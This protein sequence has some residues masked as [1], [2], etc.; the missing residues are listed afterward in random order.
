[1]KTA[2][3]RRHD[4]GMTLPE[5]LI[6]V[7]VL[8]MIMSVLAS[9]VIVTL[10]QQ[11]NTTG[12]LNV[13]RSEQTIGMWIPADLSSADTVDTSPDATPCGA[14]TCDGID[15][16]TGSNVLLLSWSTELGEGRTTTTNV[17]YHFAPAASGDDYHLTRVVCTSS[18]AGW[19]CSSFV[20]L[21]ELP[22]PPAGEAFVPG[23]AHGAACRAAV[24]PTP[25]TR[26]DWV[27]IVSEPLAA[28]ATGDSLPPTPVNE[29]ARKDA[30]RVIVSI[31]GGGDSAGA[32]GGINQISITAGGTVRGQIAAN[33]VQGA[34]SFVEARSRCGGPMTVVVDESN[35]IGSSITDVKAGVRRFVEALA[36]TPVQLQVVR[37]HT[38]A[39]ALGSSDWHRYF[40]MTDQADVD[41]L[42]ASIDGLK[43]SWSGSPNGGTNWEE[44]LFRTFYKADG[45]TADVIPETVVFF[46]DGVPTFD[47]LVHKSS[48]GIIPSE[49]PAPTAPWPASTGSSY[50]QVAFRRADYI[51][52]QFRRSVR[53]V[54][55]G[56]G[57]GITQS[58][59]WVSDPGAGYRLVWE[60]GSYSYVRDDYTYKAR[61]QKRNSS[62]SAWYWVSKA[63]YS[64]TSS[65][66]RRDKGWTT[67]S[68]AEFLSF[69]NP[70]NSN[71]NT[72]NGS[73]D[74]GVRTLTGSTPVSTA[75]YQAKSSNSAYRAIPKTYDNGPD[76][77]IWTGS[78]SSGSSDEYRSSKVYNSPPYDGYD[79][80][81]TASTRNDVILARLIAGN[82][83][84]TPA[85][86]DGT[87][88]T[89]AEIAD[90]YVLPQ[91][92]QFGR[93]MEAVALGEC[94]GTLTLQTKIN[95]TTSAPDPF[96]YQNSA[97][98]DSAGN[99]VALEPTVV[100]TNQQF[101]TGTFDFTVPNGQFVTVDILPQN[102]S[103]LKSYIP[104][105]WSC[106]AGNS[107]RAVT[108][109][110][111]PDGGAWKG[112]RIKVS[113]NEAVSCTLSVTR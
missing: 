105:D 67:V 60:R 95:G 101:T 24:D 93:A 3:E 52:N 11:D 71:N 113:A 68:E 72:G 10:R 78:R 108:L 65:S 2:P 107:P 29:S 5:V 9:A 13:A 22:G 23:V 106:R 63:T 70:P 37:F 102:Y 1:M 21:R 47:R 99:P 104:G 43:G 76:W 58:S 88:Y 81:V 49:P 36:G 96:R 98:Q 45:S 54:G 46:T 19:S 55:V 89:N 103:E 16:T 25:C 56:V 59:N 34:P 17:S 111:I 87:T 15:L 35:S 51:S 39:S 85:T 61:Y 66:N 53:L 26:P 30:N 64:A 48:P 97:V 69:E 20:V 14:V 27:I 83:Y 84:G 100:T 8:G 40:D 44:A 92:S 57:S 31:N 80:A 28:D 33:S 32:G 91:W 75:Q 12:R 112:A 62:S 110:D 41:T 86:W 50:S 18:G 6:A 4:A 7:V 79:P 109:I 90:M 38:Y 73:N 42:L 74:G 77:E 94:G 82:D